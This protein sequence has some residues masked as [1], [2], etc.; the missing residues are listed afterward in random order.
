MEMCEEIKVLFKVLKPKADGKLSL[1][2]RGFLMEKLAESIT[3]IQKRQRLERE[4][5]QHNAACKL[6]KVMRHVLFKQ[7]QRWPVFS[8]WIKDGRRE[9]FVKFQPFRY[10][11]EEKLSISEQL[12]ALELTVYDK[13]LKKTI[14]VESYTFEA[15]ITFLRSDLP[16]QTEIICAKIQAKRNHLQAQKIQKKVKVVRLVKKPSEKGTSQIQEAESE[17]SFK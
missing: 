10:F 8:I 7:T 15:F 6:Q 16:M 4:K 2:E 13:L 11:K 5:K 14:I 9:Y 17:F 1:D 12:A 3:E